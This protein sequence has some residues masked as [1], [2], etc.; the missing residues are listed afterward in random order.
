MQKY[1]HLSQGGWITTDV[2]MSFNWSKS[3]MQR[4]QLF[5]FLGAHLRKD[6]EE[7]GRADKEA[8]GRAHRDEGAGFQWV[9][10]AG[11]HPVLSALVRV[12]LLTKTTATTT[13]ECRF[14]FVP[15]RRKPLRPRQSASEGKT[16]KGE[17]LRSS[18]GGKHCC[19]LLHP[20]CP[21]RQQRTDAA[22]GLSQRWSF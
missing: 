5:P 2:R 6:E 18:S 13:C 8:G 19:C 11:G 12:P 7:G 4:A 17:K 16:I 3:T 14:A 20:V 22:Y 15:F 9:G 21:G 1:R 10:A